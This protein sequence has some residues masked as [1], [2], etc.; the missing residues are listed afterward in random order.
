[1]GVPRSKPG[2]GLPGDVPTGVPRGRAVRGGRG[3]GACAC[4]LRRHGDPGTRVVAMRHAVDAQD[5]IQRQRGRMPSCRCLP[6]WWGVE[7]VALGWVARRPAAQRHR[8][9]ASPK[10]SRTARSTRA[11][12]SQRD[13][14]HQQLR[15]AWR[16]GSRSKTVSFLGWDFASAAGLPTSLGACAKAKPGS[17][18]TSGCTASG[19]TV[20]R[21]S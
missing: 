17:A 1:M 11:G 12:L 16:L 4:C 5:F 18:A 15:Q 20:I 7:L 14:R 2:K 19:R 10:G 13:N 9:S 21:A 8:P 3:R 6:S